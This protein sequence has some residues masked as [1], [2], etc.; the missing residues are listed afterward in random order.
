MKKII[1]AALAAAALAGCSKENATTPAAPV[2]AAAP[3]QNATECS[4]G[5]LSEGQYFM[6]NDVWGASKAGAGSQC[7]YFNSI[8]DWGVN[9]SHTN[10]STG[11]KAYPAVVFGCHYGGCSSGTGLPKK[12]S[13][14]GNVHTWFTQSSSG[15]AYDAAYDIW[16]D[17]SANP[18]NRAATYELMIWLTWQNTNPIA[19]A[20]DASGNAV[21]YA[22]NVSLSGKTWN[23]Y[24]RN[25]VFSFLPTTKTNWVSLDAKPIIDYCVARG[26]M[27]NAN[28]M[29]SVQAG[30]EIISGGTFKTT[31][32]G[33][34]GI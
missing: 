10:T 7:I 24:R 28:Y 19:A 6:M 2:A 9:A 20:Y 25:N 23:I 32:Y 30:W 12:I 26:W 27:S 8:N 16:F 18:G 5:S 29:T 21:P 31:S 11:I 1:I 3:P 22:A 17:P 33:V 13:A 15:T 4:G 34:S 14:L